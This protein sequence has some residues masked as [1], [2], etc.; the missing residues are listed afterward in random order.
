MSTSPTALRNRLVIATTLWRDT[1]DEPL[2]KIPPGE[3][4][5]QI[6]D[7]EMVLVDMMCREATPET[8][9]RIA[10]QTW[11]LVQDRPDDDPV[12]KRV[13]DCHEQLAKLSHP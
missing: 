7:F 5:A 12:K 4:A 2:P 1:T 13:V 3:P 8:A 11:D 10:D 9:K 6:Q